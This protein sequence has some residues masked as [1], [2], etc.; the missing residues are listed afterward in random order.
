MITHNG[1][2][3]S[4]DNC[5]CNRKTRD[6]RNYKNLCRANDPG[7]AIQNR[8]YS[9]TPTG[10]SEAFEKVPEMQ[11]LM[12]PISEYAEAERMIDNRKGY[13]Y[14]AYLKALEYK[15]NKGGN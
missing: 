7:V 9:E 2:R 8:V 10:L 11:N 14:S 15:E 1:N 3:K 6:S 13:V 12:I 4:K 5:N